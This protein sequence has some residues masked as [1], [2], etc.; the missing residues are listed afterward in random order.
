MKSSGNPFAWVNG[1]DRSEI[2]DFR[3]EALWFILP[4]VAIASFTWGLLRG[5]TSVFYLLWPPFAISVVALFFSVARHWNPRSTSLLASLLISWILLAAESL[6]SQPDLAYVAVPLVA[7]A[8]LMLNL[9]PSLVFILQ[10]SLGMIVL[11]LL[12]T[13]GDWAVAVTF[14]PLICAW[15]TWF[16]VRLGYRPHL[17]AL[18]AARGDREWAL[19]QYESGKGYQGELRQ[20]LK[21]LES[22]N[23]QINKQNQALEEARF[24]AEQ[25]RKSKN[26]FAAMVSHELLTPIN[27]IAGYSEMICK[28]PRAYAGQPLPSAYRGDVWAIFHSAQHLRSLI[29]DVLDLSCLD[30]GKL[31]LY[32][33][34]IDSGELL[35]QVVEIAHDLVNQKGLELI[36]DLPPDPGL[37]LVD[38]KRIRQV[39]LNLIKNGVR[40]TE[41]G[42]IRL[43]I[44]RDRQ[45]GTILHSVQDTGVGIQPEDIPRLF[46]PFEQLNRPLNRP[47]DG[48]GLGLALCKSFIEEHGGR[49]WVESRSGSGS[50]FIFALEEF[51]PISVTSP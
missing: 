2:D 25:A 43:C 30:T 19:R 40:Y 3:N 34:V 36:V 8:T 22:A 13:Q 35:T 6:W 28:S 41:T 46:Q 29:S 32:K 38:V 4:L 17:L 16:F 49:I 42:S 45:C 20:A 11:V 39:W 44:Q 47:H 5:Y 48:T 1:L 12:R 24:E 18:R 21:Q 7:F 37:L 31:T 33:E 9:V 23:Y 26:E 14:G 15:L 27:L 10:L 51:H 50:K